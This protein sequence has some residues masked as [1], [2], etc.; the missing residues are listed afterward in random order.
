MTG[1]RRTA[2]A[3]LVVAALACA[4]TP[5]AAQDAADSA[6]S[7][8][9]TDSLLLDAAD[10]GALRPHLLNLTTARVAAAAWE[11]VPRLVTL[12]RPDLL[13]EFLGFWEDRCGR[14]E[15][16]VRTRL[17][18]AIWD[19]AFD[20]GLYDDGIV[21]DLDAWLQ[22]SPQ[23]MS[24]GRLAFDRFTIVF[25]D[26]L[27]PHQ[28]AG[29]LPEYFCLVYSD[30]FDEAADLLR[31]ADLADTWLRWYIDHPDGA[32]GGQVI[33][34]QDEPAAEGEAGPSS[35]LLTVGSWR[36][37]GDVALAGRHV[38]VGGVLEQELG[39]WFVRLPIEVRLGR[40]D[41]PYLVDQDGVQAYSDRFDAVYVGLEGGRALW[42]TGRLRLDGFVGLGYDGIRPFLEQDIMLAT[43]NLNLGLGLRWQPMP[44]PWFLGLDLRREWL[45]TRNEGPDSLGGGALS[46][47]LGIGRRLGGEAS[48]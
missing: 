44:Q 6:L 22:R 36:P 41:R 2:A 46:A 21:E 17:L 27:L 24:E 5:A 23:F 16:L 37:R 28:P 10:F 9:L 33:P 11:L 19:G 39:S 43:V 12:G 8:A 1:P 42:R 30:R 3:L 18:G 4:V 15:P 38:L 48:R 7:A 26:Q 25:A 29:S 13:V 14:S 20:E 31:G 35:L 34:G 40:T 32:E 47:R 45:G